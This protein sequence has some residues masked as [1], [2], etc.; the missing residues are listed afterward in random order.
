MIDPRDAGYGGKLDPDP[1]T[2]G[3]R[4]RA[5]GSGGSAGMLCVS[6][7]ITIVDDWQHP[8]SFLVRAEDGTFWQLVSCDPILDG[9]AYVGTKLQNA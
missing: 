6:A 7:L 8:K 1:P 9:V 4:F 2:E 3:A 5:L